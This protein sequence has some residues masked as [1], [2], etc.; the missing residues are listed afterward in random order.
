MA[1]VRRNREINIFNFSF[2]D[3]LSCSLGI[4]L[5]ILIIVILQLAQRG[6]KLNPDQVELEKKIEALEEALESRPDP[7]DEDGLAAALEQTKEKLRKAEAER[8]RARD[9]LAEAH[10]ED[11]DE[12]DDEA[13][14]RGLL[15]LLDEMSVA[16]QAREDV[17]FV[18][19]ASGSA[20]EHFHEMVFEL[21]Y[22]LLRIPDG[23]RFTLVAAGKETKT[24]NRSLVAADDESRASAKAFLTGL[25]PGGETDLRSALEG[26]LKIRGAK[27][28]VLLTDGVQT[29]PIRGKRSKPAEARERIKEDL[30][31][32]N[33]SKTVKIHTVGF[34][35]RYDHPLLLTIARENG[36]TFQSWGKPYKEEG[37]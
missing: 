26:A 17:V 4:I 31:K 2:L 36:G 32:W 19:D 9:E 22:S 24:W 18:V 1:T 21:L 3:I 23:K 5:F 20:E 34:G 27:H 13:L 6:A 35:R 33:V 7:G 10:K 12:V 15:A 29:A 14:H 30:A 8:D 16:P 11:A 25:T 28:V 37:P